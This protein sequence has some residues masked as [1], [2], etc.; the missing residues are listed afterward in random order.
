[1]SLKQRL[2]HLGATG[3]ILTAAAF[4]GPVESGKRP[5]LEPY[6]DIGG[7]PTWCYGETVGTPKARYT[8]AECDEML[9]HGVARYW[10]GIAPYVPLEAPDSVKAAMVSV[11]YNVGVGG[12]A[13]EL[14]YRANG[15]TYRVPSRF[16]TALARHDWKA[17]CDAITAPWAVKQGV[18]KGFKAT[19]KGKPVRG[20]ENRRAAE[21]ALC[22][23]DL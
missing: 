8:L 14:A 20:L 1:V 4:L 18:A 9:L 6:A 22:Y 17:T 5:Q 12:W 2:I 16:R 21:K 13:W 11:A 15:S 23:Q 7:V 3:A 10:T 19:V